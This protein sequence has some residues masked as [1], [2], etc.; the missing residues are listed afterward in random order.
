MID[1]TESCLIKTDKLV[2]RERKESKIKHNTD[3][4]WPNKYQSNKN[5]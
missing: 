3:R 1:K 2:T 4:E 5:N